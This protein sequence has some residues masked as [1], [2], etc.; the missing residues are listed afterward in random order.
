MKTKTNIFIAFILNLLFSVFELFG[1][2]FTGSVAILSDAVHDLG[3]ALSIGGSYILEKISGKKP[4]ERY[5]Y[6]YRR[7][8]VLGGVITTLILLV[9]SS[10]VIY[11][12]IARITAP[13]EI[14]YDGMILFAIVGLV[15]NSV[16][17]YFTHGG[18]SINQRA[19]NLHMLEDVFGW[20]FVL[21]GAVVMRFT[22]FYIIDPILSI[23]LATFIIINSILNLK[24]ILDIFLIKIPDGIDI[25]ELTECVK[26]VDGVIDVHH[27]HVWTLDGEENS[28]TLH[29]VS[30]E[31]GADI[32]NAVK[33]EI[34]KHGISHITLEL[35]TPL[36][37][38]EEK[39]CEINHRTKTCHHHHHHHHHS[40]SS[41]DQQNH[42][43]TH[44]CDIHHNH[45]LEKEIYQRAKF[46]PLKTKIT[47]D[48][49]MG[50]N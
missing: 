26:N 18:K 4:N 17:T 20:L 2:F 9:S 13:T 48:E 39:N 10:F 16:A 44:H 42:Q 32:K 28:A 37:N 45:N 23:V 33:K 43:H 49:K 15:V 50:S 31:I 35:E 40:H 12:A 6:G 11:N 47:D 34:R 41:T 25:S 19:V 8:S 21:V 1:G 14:N 3:D 5:T 22:N 36:E 24:Q 30:N 7:F 46:E 27:I 29:V 38:C